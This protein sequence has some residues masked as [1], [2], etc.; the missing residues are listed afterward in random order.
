MLQA[1]TI[2]RN[3]TT[4]TD[5]R[6]SVMLRSVRGYLYTDV[7]EQPVCTMFKFQAVGK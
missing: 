7:S 2:I 4:M 5:F 1:Y 6:S 3:N